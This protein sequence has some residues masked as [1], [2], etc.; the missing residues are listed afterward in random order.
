[1]IAIACDAAAFDLKNTIAFLLKGK[2][3]AIKDFGTFSD[4][5]CD[6]P[7]F[8]I[9]AAAAVQSGECDKGILL[10]GTGI[11]MSMVANKFKGIR[12]A[13][14]TDVFSAKATREHNDAN[15]LAVGARIT[16]E[17]DIFDICLAFLSTEFSGEERHKRRVDKIKEIE[18]KNFV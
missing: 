15:I 7:D 18:H 16:S 5:S 13:H 8:A 3:Y 10:C 1:M 2:G 12:C 9:M 17:K 14:C 6:Y 4:E 11:G